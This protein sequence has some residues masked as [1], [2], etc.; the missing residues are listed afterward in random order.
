M[1]ICPYTW[2]RDVF[3]KGK[4]TSGKAQNLRVSVTKNGERVV[5]VALPARSARW[6]IDLIPEDVLIKI[7][8]EGIP[9]EAIQSDLA[10]RDVLVPQGIFE[11]KEAH[12]VVQVW[13]E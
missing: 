11:L 1:S 5:D 4:S 2:F 6:L 10:T 8:S 12:R 3:S 9:I 7:R 13:L